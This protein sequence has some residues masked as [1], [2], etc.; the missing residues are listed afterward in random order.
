VVRQ[1]MEAL[2]YHKKALNGSNILLI[3]LAYKPNVD[4][5]RESPTYKLME[6]FEKQG[7][8]VSYY[9]SYVPKIRPSREYAHYAGRTSVEWD[10]E[11]ISQFDAAVI[12]TDHDDINYSELA[13]WS[14]CIVDTRNAM[15]GIGTKEKQVWKA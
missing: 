4:D 12:A 6:L 10:K 11:T 15:N 13:D 7:A 5:D 9:D 2:N 3:G 1:T 8:E 14:E